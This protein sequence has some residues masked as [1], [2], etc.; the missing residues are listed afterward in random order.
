MHN[1]LDNPVWQAELAAQNLELGTPVTVSRVIEAA[2]HNIWQT[3]TEPGN[4]K[5]VHPFCAANDVEQWPGV[6]ARD[7]ITY[8][9]GVH[10]QRDFVTWLE[11]IGYDL[12]I[13]PPPHKTAY[14]V[15]RINPLSQ[16]RSD[17]S[18]QVI[19]YLK[20][21]LSEPRKVS[22]QERFFGDVIGQYLDSVVKGVDYAATT[23]QTVRKNQFGSHPIYSD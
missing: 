14:V 6:G 13:G 18:I 4:L 8:Y 7:T 1:T 19:P 9:S 21:D 12:E 11:G 10:Y 20:I 2:S 3:I 15:W 23:G 5:R 22:Y 16:T 17:F